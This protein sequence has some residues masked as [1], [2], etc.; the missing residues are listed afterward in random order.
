MWSPSQKKYSVLAWVRPWASFTHLAA[1]LDVL[2]PACVVGVASTALAAAAIISVGFVAPLSLNVHL[3]TLLRVTCARTEWTTR[4]RAIRAVAISAPREHLLSP[5]SEML[6]LK[7]FVL[8]NGA[9]L[10]PLSS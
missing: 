6:G 7:A 4:G 8:V 1:M 3:V 10:N 2:I 9:F 5:G